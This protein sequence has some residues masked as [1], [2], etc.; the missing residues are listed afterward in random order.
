MDLSKAFDTL[1]HDLLIAKLEVYGFSAKSLISYIHN[2][3]NKRLRKTKMSIVILVYGK[4]S[5]QDFLDDLLLVHFY[6][7][8]INA[9]LFSC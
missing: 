5:S 1:N 8:Y 9:I 7:I 2:Y 6:L 3:L 4:K